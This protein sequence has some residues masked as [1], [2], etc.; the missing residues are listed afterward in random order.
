M[1]PFFDHLSARAATIDELLSDA[2]EPLPGQKGDTDLATRRLAAWCRASASADWLLFGRR[3][4]RDGLAFDRV[5][6]RL[7]T[8]RRRA[9]APV[10]LWAEDAQWIEPALRAA[11]DG[12]IDNTVP[13]AH[14]LAPLVE[15]AAARLWAAIPAPALDRLDASARADLC[16]RLLETLAELCAAPLYERFAGSRRYDAFVADMRGAGWRQLFESKPVLLR[17]IATV[18]RQWLG[19]MREFVARLHADWRALHAE[20]LR[21]DGTGKVVGIGGGLSDPHNGGRAVLALRFGDGARLFYKPKD[22]QVDGV[23]LAMVERLNRNGA[24]IAL[25][26]PVAV[27][28]DG[29]GWTECVEHVG[30]ADV[31]GLRRFFRRAGAWLALFHAFSGT[32][33]HQENIIAAGEHPVPIDLETIL[34]IATEEPGAQAEESRAFE[35]AREIVANSVMAV[36]MLPAYGRSGD[37]DLFA[38]GGMASDWSGGLKR[39]WR[40]LNTD[41]M[42]PV[43]A[44]ETGKPTPNLPHIDGRYARFGDHVEDLVGGFESY[45]RFLL[46]MRERYGENDLLAG[47]AGLAV[48][49]VVRPTQFYYMLL[50]RLRNDRTMDDGASWSAQADF[51]ARLADWEGDDDP[52]WPLQRAERDALVSLNVPHFAM[53]SDGHAI[54]DLDGASATIDTLP[55][56][57]RARLRLRSLSAAEIAWQAQVIRQN[58][59]AVSTSQAGAAD[60]A[61]PLA[62]PV[63]TRA[64]TREAFVAEADAIADTIARQAIRR[65]PGA[66]WIGLGWFADSEVSQLA[67]LGPDL[68]NGV[69]GIGVFLAAH[70]AATGA[71]ASGELARAAVARLRRDLAGR[72]AARMVRTLG[73]GGA[74]GLGSIVYGLS[75]MAQQLRDDALRADAHAAAGLFSADLIAADRRL[76]VIGGS[77]GAILCLLRLHRDTGAD[78][79]L[80]L[81]LRCGEHLMAQPRVGEPGRRSWISP[82]P[83]RQPLNGMSHGAAGFAYALASLA[84]ATGREDF[85]DAAAECVAFENASYDAAHGNWP[86]LREAEPNWRSQWCHGAVGIGLARLAMTRHGALR[87][88]PASADIDQALAGAGRAWPGHVDTLCCGTLGSV[89]FFREAGRVLRR[90]DLQ[91]MAAQRL[92]GV[93]ESAAASGDYRWNGGERR[94]N[95]GLFRGLAGVGY[96]CLRQAGDGLPNVLIWE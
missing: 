25:R 32:D 76:D 86:D 67:V 71:T 49:R 94:F 3:L 33:M 10:P 27:V 73:I 8:V 53:R 1:D 5:L 42:K 93:L 4:A 48:R 95:L 61:K 57:E 70:A 30:C 51:L 62:Y 37:N 21:A 90:A 92:A 17:L 6:A 75:V 14:L 13:F 29:Y 38:I 80:R 54:S 11:P 43:M 79:V 58:S 26:A 60:E 66:A 16:H 24:P 50:H 46:S 39:V 35:A 28:R 9:G 81:A 72:G 15:A 31:E 56:L 18:T 83:H 34:Q 7:A 74:T 23:W 63:A 82:G 40:D 41:A 96:T 78:D 91:S 55:G 59:A 45:A 47:F 2:F 69:C 89:E 12:P 65:G 64:P 88:A 87:C 19:T 84:A 85:A 22:L 20:I 52:T 77:A 36:G 44:P 68:Y